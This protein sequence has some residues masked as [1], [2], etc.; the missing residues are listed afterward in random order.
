M[1]PGTQKAVLI[2]TLSKNSS[3][4]TSSRENS[5]LVL[6]KVCRKVNETYF[7]EWLPETARL[8]KNYLKAC[9]EI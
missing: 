8:E 6:Y 5:R 2:K 4:N 1:S 9:M 7:Y 3:L